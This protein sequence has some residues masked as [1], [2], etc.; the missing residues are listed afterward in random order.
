MPYLQFFLFFLFLHASR[1]DKQT[2]CKTCDFDITDFFQGL[3]PYPVKDY[4]IILIQVFILNLALFHKKFNILFR[5]CFSNI[6]F[7]NPIG[8]FGQIRIQLINWHRLQTDNRIASL[9]YLFTLFFIDIEASDRKTIA[10]V[11][12]QS[13]YLYHI[14]DFISDPC[15]LQFRASCA[16]VHSI[17]SYFS[18]KDHR[19]DVLH[20]RVREKIQLVYFRIEWRKF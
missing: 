7:A 20:A 6:K 1:S 13:L 14:A 2:F 19:A 17:C 18:I 10:L 9:A 16:H 8:L 15:I 11:F 3:L 5:R 12:L 4:I